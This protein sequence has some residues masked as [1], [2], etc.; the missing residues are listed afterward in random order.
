[1]ITTNKI[2]TIQNQIKLA[3]QK[4]ERE[5]NV[6]I[7]F[8]S[9]RY[10][11]VEYR[12]KMTVRTTEKSNLATNADVRLSQSY[13]FSENIIG[14]TFMSNGKT[15]KITEFKTRNRMYPIIATCNGSLDPTRYKF[16]TETIKSKLILLT[17]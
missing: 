13:G 2:N 3:L 1:M 5:N 6:K 17:D 14:K 8:G 15:F 11:D 10:S 9:C 16:S 4:I 7:S 12:T